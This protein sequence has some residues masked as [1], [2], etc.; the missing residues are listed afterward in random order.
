[1][2][3]QIMKAQELIGEKISNIVL[4]GSG[5]PLDNFEETIKFVDLANHPLSLNIGQRHISLSTCG[6]VPEIYR[7]ADRD[8]QINLSISLHA[9]NDAKRKE[10]MPI[11]KRYSIE[12]LLD[13]CAYYIEKT[14]RRVTF[15]YALIK[16]M[17]DS[18]YD[19]IEVAHLLQGMLCH[20]NLIPINP[21]KEKDFNKSEAT[22]IKSF[23][24]KL[25]SFG[26]PTSI[27]REM[28]SSINASCG[29]LRQGYLENNI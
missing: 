14:N 3:D 29:Q 23:K 17:N 19:A 26:I 21:I 18:F 9:P 12:E 2:L 24:E 13:A 15:E 5:E 22:S 4:M 16:G 25:E 8:L 28:G 27:R 20:V 10:L 6:L 1:M 7:L 11:A